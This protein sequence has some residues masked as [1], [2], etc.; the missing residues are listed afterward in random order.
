MKL[1]CQEKW[2]V[3]R[4]SLSLKL[5]IALHLLQPGL[6]RLPFLFSVKLLIQFILVEVQI[7]NKNYRVYLFEKNWIIV[8]IFVFMEDK[9]S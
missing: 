7:L 6:L 5:T 9:S 4:N 1:T 8:L 2:L 3:F